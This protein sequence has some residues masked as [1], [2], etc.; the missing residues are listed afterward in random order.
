M[1]YLG[2]DIAK[3][4]FQ[5]ALLGDGQRCRSRSFPNTHQG[6]A[7][8]IEWLGKTT[9]RP[10]HVA[11]E[12]TGG[13]EEPLAVWLYEQGVRVSVINPLLVKNF[14]KSLGLRAKTD[15]VDARLIARYVQA[16]KP[17]AWK[18]DPKEI[19]QLRA[20]LRRIKALE[21]MRRQELNRALHPSVPLID[22]Q[23]KAHASYLEQSIS[24]LWTAVQ[25]HIRRHARLREQQK[26]LM[27]IPGI[28]Q[29]A[30]AWLL[31]EIPFHRFIHARQ[32]AAF[33]GVV[34]HLET[35]GTSLSTS[36]MSKRGNRHI[37]GVLYMPAVSAMSWNPAVRAHAQRLRARHKPGKT[38]TVAAIRK[39]IHIAF[40]VIH[41]GMPFD[42]KK[43]MAS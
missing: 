3:D 38:V 29:V 24:Q 12:A 37:R 34:P 32:A 11:M 7:A 28:S 31:G 8:L 39:L 15:S 42:P 41:S 33:A 27:T 25:E 6:F 23:L 43:A 4:T 19:R 16:H 2:I 21:K 13:F 14:A 20:L 30:S 26:L 5:A 36:R 9:T 18:P 1:D 17:R 40:G 22:Q 35:S 10:V